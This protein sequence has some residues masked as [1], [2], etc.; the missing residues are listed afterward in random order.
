M[1]KKKTN[2]TKTPK[3]DQK[4]VVHDWDEYLS[5]ISFQMMPANSQFKA[6]LAVELLTWAREQPDACHLSEF[7][8]IKGIP[9]A[10]FH[11]WRHQV[12]ELQHAYD[13]VQYIFASRLRK[14]ILKKEYAEN[15]G[16]LILTMYDKEWEE[17]F[18]WRAQLNKKAH[19]DDSGGTKIVVIDRMPETSLVPRR[20]DKEDDGESS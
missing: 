5:T 12:K 20:Q 16:S 1:T 19:E 9:N 13:E 7:L 3:N 8:L 6:R 10:T 18:M 4:K 2:S 17:R 11:K 14:N 15:F